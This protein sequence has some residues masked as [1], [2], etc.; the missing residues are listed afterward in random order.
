VAPSLKSNGWRAKLSIAQEFKEGNAAFQRSGRN[1][2][3]EHVVSAT[4]LNHKWIGILAALGFW[5]FHVVRAFVP[6]LSHAHAP[7][8]SRSFAHARPQTVDGAL[9]SKA[10]R[11]RWS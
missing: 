6:P 1:F 4:L 3:K 10:K 11:I 8:V 2:F 5:Y 9:R 7:L